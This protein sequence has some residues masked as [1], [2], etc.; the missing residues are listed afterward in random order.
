MSYRAAILTLSDKGSRG[1]REDLSGAAA[2]CL[3]RSAGYE[4]VYQA[5]LSDDRAPMEKEMS[6]LCDEGVCDLLLTTGGT[7]FSPRDV[8]PE[9]TQSVGE[10]NVPGIA[11][12]MRA[13]SMRITP[14]GMLSRAV[15]VIRK[16]TLIVNLPGS[17]RAVEE[18]L[19]Y[20]L[21][22]L[23]HGLGILT[24][25]ESECGNDERGDGK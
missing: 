10:R 21:P 13:F 16:N 5:I 3:L 23:S 7:G 24:G 1:E 18:N 2:A 8:T 11:E 12:A 20:I 15:S 6:R 4:I 22:T 19:A 14:R 17:P 25:R 9:A